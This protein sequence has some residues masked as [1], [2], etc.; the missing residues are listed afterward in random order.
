MR[1]LP[2]G[3]VCNLFGYFVNIPRTHRDDER[4]VAFRE[5]LIAYLVERIDC[6]DLALPAGRQTPRRIRKNMVRNGRVRRFTRGINWGDEGP[7][8]ARERRGKIIEKTS[9]AAIEMRMECDDNSLSGNFSRAAST[10]ARM[11]VG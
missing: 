7:V 4:V 3:L 9:C 2:I 11:A 1:G 6:C 10:V 8:R 5:K